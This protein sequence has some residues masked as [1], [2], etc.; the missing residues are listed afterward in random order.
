MGRKFDSPFFI[1]KIKVMPSPIS[2][3]CQYCV[4]NLINDGN[5]YQTTKQ[6][7]QSSLRSLT[8]DLL[9]WECPRCVTIHLILD[10]PAYFCDMVSGGLVGLVPCSERVL[11]S[12]L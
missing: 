7:V 12:E 10:G 5:K 2:A 1:A 3:T 11:V 9:S 6:H 8:P 4:I